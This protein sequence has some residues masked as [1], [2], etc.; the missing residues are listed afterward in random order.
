[1]VFHDWVGTVFGLIVRPRRVHA[2]R[3]P[4][5]AEQ[6][7]ASEGGHQWP[8]TPRSIVARRGSRHRAVA[9]VR[10]APTRRADSRKARSDPPLRGSPMAERR[11]DGRRR[12]GRARARPRSRSGPARARAATRPTR[13]GAGGD[14]ARGGPAPVGAE[15]V[16]A[17]R[18]RCAGGRATSSSD[19]GYSVAHASAAAFT[20]LSDMGGAPHARRRCAGHRSGRDRTPAW[21]RTRVGGTPRGRST[22]DRRGVCCPRC[23]SPVPAVRAGVAVIRALV[24]QGSHVVAVDAD[25]LAAGLYLADEHAVVAPASEPTRSSPTS[26]RRRSGS[27]STSS[28]ARWPRRCSSSPVASADLDGARSGSH[29]TTPS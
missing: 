1:M 2:L 7:A 13:H 24:E 28:S 3:V 4:A 20:R 6:Q 21:I 25:P 27:R 26:P 8:V 19:Q 11:A 9:R 15:R 22:R 18:R 23:S 5:A 29:R 10:V 12:A 16:A 17:R 14:R